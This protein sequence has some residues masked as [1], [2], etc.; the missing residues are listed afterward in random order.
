MKH[1]LTP[2]IPVVLIALA[3]VVSGCGPQVADS[4]AKNPWSQWERMPQG[5]DFFPIGVW[6]QDPRHAAQYRAMGVDYYLALFGGPTPEQMAALREAGMATVCDFND[7]ARENLLDDPL[8]WGWMHGDE[9]DLAHVYP[10][11]TLMGPGGMDILKQHWP[12]VHAALVAE[13]KTYEGWGMGAN[14][15]DLQADYAA[16]KEAD[17]TRPVLIQL[18]K[19]VALEGKIAG[20]GDHSGRLDLYPGY[21]AA[22]DLVS[23]D[24]YPVAYGDADKLWQV[25]RGL[26][27][28]RAW[29][30]GERPIMAI[31]EAGF[32][33]SQYANQ[34]QQRAQAWMA[35]NH[36]A[37]SITWFCHRWMMVDGRNTNV[38]TAMPITE[39]QVGQAVKAINDE[40]HGLAAAIN[41]PVLDGAATVETSNPDVP[42]EMTARRHGGA[43]YLFAVS[44]TSGTTDA[45]FTVPGAADGATVEVLN[46]GRTLTVKDGRFSDAFASD[47]DVNLYRIR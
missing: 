33:D 32:G 4:P 25:P 29:G 12:E 10:R 9:P 11:D 26:D 41:S 1:M 42:V 14:P 21:M 23:F 45:T 35:I 37:S 27:N 15:L 7:Y 46:E 3:A 6:A 31:L 13:G 8:V 38:S 36:G 22:S 24:I 34:A 40:I 17:P 20:R 30:A 43:T 28:L 47:F 19:A 44:M 18:S 39:P 2:L 16:I 5:Q